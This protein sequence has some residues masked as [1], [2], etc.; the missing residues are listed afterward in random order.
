M[1]RALS[2]IL[3]LVMCLALCACGTSSNG[4]SK[5]EINLVGA[6]SGSDNHAGFVLLSSGK[7]LF[8]ASNLDKEADSGHF[9]SSGTWEVEG[10]Y[11]IIHFE[12]LFAGGSV[13][14]AQVYKIISNNE[15]ISGQVTYTKD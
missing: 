5:E 4:L 8:N 12:T 7:A 10:D 3:A 1:K 14:N 11:L 9:S 15:V 13:D 6:W 2:L